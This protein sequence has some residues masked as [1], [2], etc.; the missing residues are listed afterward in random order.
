MLTLSWTLFHVSCLLQP[1]LSQ[2]VIKNPGN[3]PGVI[4]EAGS[5]YI[6]THQQQGIM[7]LKKDC[8]VAKFSTFNWLVV[9]LILNLNH[10]FISSC[11]NNVFLML[12][13]I[14]LGEIN[15]RRD[16]QGQQPVGIKPHKVLAP[17]RNYNNFFFKI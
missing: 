2:S 12:I 10:K 7:N 17:R 14:R 11:D 3:I 4:G 15:V 1:A 16:P 13:Q 5:R 8:Q 6:W 9:L